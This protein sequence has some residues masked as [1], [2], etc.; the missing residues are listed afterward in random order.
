[1]RDERELDLYRAER[2]AA[3]YRVNRGAR[4]LYASPAVAGDTG[5]GLFD[6]RNYWLI[7]YKHRVLI[8]TI[9]TIVLAVTYYR[10]RTAPTTYVASTQVRIDPMGPQ[11]INLREL[12]VPVVDSSYYE[13]E[14]AVLRSSSH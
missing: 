13:T 14:Y 3:A 10:I 11:Y 9:M 2:E 5:S 12:V 6:V 8:L 7:F 1:M 4:S